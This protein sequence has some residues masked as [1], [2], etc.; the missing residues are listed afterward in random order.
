M[1]PSR[2]VD[3]Q[4]RVYVF[5]LGAKLM[6]ASLRFRNKWT[7]GVAQA[8]ASVYLGANPGR[9]TLGFKCGMVGLPNDGKSTLFNA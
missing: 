1:T 6:A 2:H 9:N 8:R 5:A 3:N 4:I 7:Q